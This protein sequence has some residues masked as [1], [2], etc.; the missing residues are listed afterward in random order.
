MPSTVDTRTVWV[1]RCVPSILVLV[2][3]PYFSGRIEGEYRSVGGVR[4]NVLVRN[5]NTSHYTH[6]NIISGAGLMYLTH[7]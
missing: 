7:M 6:P 2:S 4:L 3:A 1:S 5:M